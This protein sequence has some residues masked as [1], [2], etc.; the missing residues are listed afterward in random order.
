MPSVGL[1]TIQG[2]TNDD[3]VI[4]TDVISKALALGYRHFDTAFQYGTEHDIGRPITR[5]GVPRQE[6][7][8]MSRM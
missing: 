7:F 5:S 6:S 3:R 2:G 4:E 8:L 1:G